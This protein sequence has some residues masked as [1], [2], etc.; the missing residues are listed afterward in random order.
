MQGHLKPNDAVT[1][2]PY[3][4]IDF[5]FQGLVNWWQQLTQSCVCSGWF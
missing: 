4:D 3:S 5:I 2:F 1:D